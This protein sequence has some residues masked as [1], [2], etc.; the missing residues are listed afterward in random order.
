MALRKAYGW[1]QGAWLV[2]TPSTKVVTTRYHD[3][4]L[5]PVWSIP[6]SWPV[7]S[8]KVMSTGASE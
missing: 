8:V 2:V 3:A 4:P 6:G 1:E 5:T 7:P